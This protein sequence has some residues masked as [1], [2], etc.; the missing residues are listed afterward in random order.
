M[1]RIIIAL[2]V[3][4]LLLSA[5]TATGAGVNGRSMTGKST[6]LRTDI[7]GKVLPGNVMLFYLG[8]CE[9]AT[10][11]TALSNDTTT[12][13]VGTNH[14]EGTYSLSYAKVN[15]TANTTLGAVYATLSADENARWPDRPYSVNITDVVQ[16]NG[17]LVGSVYVSALTNVAYAFIRIGTSSAAYNEYRLADSEM[18]VGW[19]QFRVPLNR[20][21]SVTGAGLDSD[22][23]AYIVLGVGF[24][25]ETDALAGI[26]WDNVGVSYTTPVVAS[27]EPITRAILSAIMTAVQYIDDIVK[28]DDAAFTPGTSKIAVVG[29]TFDD[30]SPDS[31]NEGDAGAGRISAN[32]CQYFNLRDGAGGEYGQHVDQYGRAEVMPFELAILDACDSATGWTAY[33]N[34]TDNL[35]TSTNHVQGT[36]GLSFDKVDGAAG[37]TTAGAYRTISSTDISKY[38]GCGG[39]LG[40]SIYISSLTDVDYAFLR[41]GTDTTNYAEWRVQDDDLVAG[42]NSA[43]FQLCQPYS[44]TGNGHNTAA[45]TH[46]GI[47]VVFDGEDDALAEIVFDPVAVSSGQHVRTSIA[48]ATSIATPNINLHRV[49]GQPVDT[50][51]GNIGNATQRVTIATDDANLATI[52]GWNNSGDAGVDIAAQ[53]L[54]AVKISDDASANAEGNPIY[55][56]TVN[57]VFDDS[58]TA[59][60]VA[61]T[62]GSVQFTMP[63]N[64]GYWLCANGGTAYVY[65]AANP[66]VTTAVG[67]FTTIVGD[68]QCKP[69]REYP[70]AKCAVIG[71]VAGGF[72]CF[73]AYDYN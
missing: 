70:S 38:L 32:R 40:T 72:I 20:P 49:G 6:E 47:G 48:T 71:A 57:P 17:L 64:D 42:W 50:G 13:A 65:C 5:R 30:V 60:C 19:N 37:T 21:T 45:I 52:A 29:Y 61:I 51:A 56:Q 33:G 27:L 63:G 46:V 43:V 24:D 67:N 26:L 22:A 73:E 10:G 25:A 8:D 58:D 59:N 18:A 7:H 14:V 44:I 2:A 4:G 35:D 53:T 11:W 36:L 54:T 16:N 34:D 39:I 15:G 69:G 68:G 31:V 55:A 41:I 23:L 28:V 3:L 1:K 66:T 12:I 9:T 62:G